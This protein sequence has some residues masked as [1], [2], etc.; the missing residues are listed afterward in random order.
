MS[1]INP[2]A[3]PGMG[4]PVLSGENAFLTGHIGTWQ[5]FPIV[6]DSSAVDTGNTPNTTLRSGLVLG[7]ITASGKY[8]QYNPAA[9]DGS[10]HAV[11]ILYG[12]VNMLN[13]VSGA[14]EDQ[15]ASLVW[16]GLVK[17]TQL[18]GLDYLA[19]RQLAHRIF[20]DDGFVDADNFVRVVAPKTSNYTVT[21]A[22]NNTIFTNRGASGAVNFTLPTIE[23]GLRYTFFA[24][25]NQPITITSA[26][27][28]TLV[29]Y[30]DN[31]ADTVSFNT[32]GEIIGG[33]FTVVA[34]DNA[35]K[36]LVLT[37]LASK[38]QTVTITT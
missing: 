8:K 1:L 16:F 20:F 4:D 17:A 26:T 6:L 13:P 21:V 18:Y 2:F 32:T 31:A 23:R 25:E 30:N 19:R 12:E 36:W 9:T 10:Q 35:S 28:D 3:M 22:D 24:E 7:K 34:N 5:I 33:A 14:A 29:V 11:G 37:N 15:A 38:V 27:A